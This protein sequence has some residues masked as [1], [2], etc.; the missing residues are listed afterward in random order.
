[1]SRAAIGGVG[2]GGLFRGPVPEPAHPCG[3][4]RGFPFLGHLGG[5]DFGDFRLHAPPSLFFGTVFGDLNFRA[6]LPL[7]FR[8]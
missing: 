5:S 7:F 3:L 8:D 6:P 1:M 2:E 4:F